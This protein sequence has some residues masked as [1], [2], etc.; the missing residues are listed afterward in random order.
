MRIKPSYPR[1]NRDHPLAAGL[2]GF[3]PMA[4]TAANNTVDVVNGIAMTRASG[5]ALYAASPQGAGI[6]FTNANERWVCPN[7]DALRP[8]G[9]LTVA[10]RITVT[11]VATNNA[12]HMALGTTGGGSS[13]RQLCLVL[14][15][16][17]SSW[18]LIVEVAGVRR[19]YF[20]S[21][22]GLTA[23]ETQDFAVTRAASGAITLYRG[24]VI[25]S[26]SAGHAGA[27]AIT[28]PFACGALDGFISQPHIQHFAAIWD[29]A[30]SA[31]EVRRLAADP[32]AIARPT[33]R[34]FPVASRGKLLMLRRRLNAA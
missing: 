20:A 26:Q 33:R 13:S 16:N 11:T 32:F 1:L 8:T 21:T 7:H 3:W 34:I 29:R 5:S 10:A 22:L 19:D 12:Y 6:Q 17:N 25:D 24:G 27:V 30:L 18:R 15:Y 14:G 2:L 23:G 4:G 28:H 9:A 31:D